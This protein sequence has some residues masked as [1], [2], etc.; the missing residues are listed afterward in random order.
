MPGVERELPLFPLGAVVLFPD[1]PLN[2]RVFE[3]RYKHLVSDVLQH[4]SSFG[5]ALIREGREVG[6][7]AV[8]HEV[9]RLRASP[10]SRRWM[11]GTCTSPPWEANAFASWRC[12]ARSRTSRPGWRSWTR[13]LW[14][15]RRS[16]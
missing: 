9:E 10:R 11:G 3:N 14:R 6:M 1:M 5:I 7:P 16:L 4:D 2:L 15:R 8:P 12:C 13:D